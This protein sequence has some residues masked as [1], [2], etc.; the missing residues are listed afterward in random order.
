MDTWVSVVIIAELECR[1]H[2]AYP[3]DGAVCL[4]IRS[5][6]RKTALVDYL[7]VFYQMSG[8]AAPF[9]DFECG[10]DEDVVTFQRPHQ[11]PG[12]RVR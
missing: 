10:T 1:R 6:V 11:L 8:V 3:F 5:I 12:L 4:K 9:A 7:E 2:S